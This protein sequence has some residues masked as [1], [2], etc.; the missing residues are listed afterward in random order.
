MWPV[1][2]NGLAALRNQR[3][4]NVNLLMSIA[5]LG[6]LAIGEFLEG[7]TIITLFALGEALEAYTMGRARASLQSLLQLAPEQALRLRDGAETWVPVTALQVDE[8]ILVRP[9]DRIP[10]DGEVLEGYS[11]VNQAP[12]T[13]E[14]LPRPVAPG[15]EVFAGS[16]NG[17]G[18]LRLRVTRPAEDSTLSR[19]IRLVEQA[20]ATSPPSWRIIDRFARYYTPLLPCWR[21][22]W[23]C[24]RRCFSAS[25]SG[26]TRARRAGC[27]AASR[28][29]S[30]PVPARCSSA[31]R[32]PVIAAI[33]AAARR[34]VLI[35]GGA[36]LEMLGRIR[37]VAF[38]KTGTL[39]TNQPGL[40]DLYALDCTERDQP[41]PACEDVLALAAAVERGSSHP[42]A[43]AIS[44]DAEARDLAGRYATATQVTALTGRGVQGYVDEQLVTPGQS[45]AL[46]AGTSASAGAVPQ[47]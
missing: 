23:P 35:H 9:G 13:G 36:Q 15:D 32:L 42:F 11:E 39:T 41:C 24:C 20:Q 18:G 30:S 25:P 12:V 46:R 37:A 1:A 40:T 34:G 14:S 21:C 47:D 7:I 19:I 22:W 28:C 2:R 33:N 16:V 27:I 10:L 26:T 8:N 43:R 45:R 29:W 6:A 17:L 38:D 31:R 3:R 5:A 44:A 4:F